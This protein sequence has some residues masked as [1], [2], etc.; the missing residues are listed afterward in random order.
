MDSRTF[1]GK[2]GEFHAYGPQG[3]KVELRIP[4]A[5]ERGRLMAYL[6]E[7]RGNDVELAIKCWFDKALA[8]DDP[9]S[10]AV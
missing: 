4:E 5:R 9:L 10:V 6:E 7:C 8:A 2:V 1:C 3:V